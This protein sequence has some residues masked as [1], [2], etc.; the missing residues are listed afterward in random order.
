MTDAIMITRGSAVLEEAIEVY[1]SGLGAN[2]AR[3]YQARIEKFMTWFAGQPPAPFAAQL[4]LYIRH[5]EDAGHKA[6]TVQ[7]HVNT[8]KGL[9]RTAAALD[10]SGR[11]AAYLPQLDLAKPPKVRGEVQGD[12]LSEAQRQALIDQ[13]GVD[14][15][16]GRRDT[17]ILALLAVCGLRRSE[18]C[19]LNW[20]HIGELDGHKVIKNLVGKHGRVRTVKM[21]AALW[22]RIID[23]AQQAEISTVWD[24]PV[25]VAIR[26]GD[27]VQHGR[28][29]TH[30]SIA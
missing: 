23:Y 6:R 20:G 18:I 13:P 9:V 2:S 24:A 30:D 28:R 29:L 1:K 14:T 26:K 25:F 7:Q 22:R 4:R 16:K 12:R 21:P 5:L 27:A 11:L 10:T 15:H 3:S 8:V 17:A 19:S